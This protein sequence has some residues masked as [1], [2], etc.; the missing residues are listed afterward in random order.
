MENTSCATRGE[1][2]REPWNKRK[3]VGQK[4][5]MAY[6]THSITR[7]KAALSYQRTKNI[8]QYSCCLGRANGGLKTERPRCW[9]LGQKLP[10]VNASASMPPT[11]RPQRE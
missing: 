9:A 1:L 4:A 8:G 7:T 2:R 3:I 5:P 6:G 10:P 11:K